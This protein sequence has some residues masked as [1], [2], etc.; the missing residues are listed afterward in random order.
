MAQG[1][2]ARHARVRRRDGDREIFSDRD[3]AVDRF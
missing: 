1:D 3:G 2:A